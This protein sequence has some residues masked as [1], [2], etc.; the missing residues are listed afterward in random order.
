M[1]ILDEILASK[2]QE[3]ASLVAGTPPVRRTAPRSFMAHLRAHGPVALIAEIKR[4]S[5]SRPMIREAFE[6][7]AMARAYEAGGAA[8]LS[9]LTDAPYFGGSLSDMAAAREA[10]GLPVLRKD[11]LIDPR[12]VHEAYAAGADALLLI[13]AALTDDRLREMMA[14]CREVGLEFLLEVHTPDEMRR[15]LALEAPLVGINN[16]DLKTFTVDLAVTRELATLARTAE[17][18]PMLVSESGIASPEDRSL[19]EAWG[20]EAMLVGE[21]L[22]RQPD[23]TLAARE[24]LA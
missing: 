6:P 5:P 18:V 4:K 24:L 3:V 11:F 8:A 21:S 7:A 20:I 13:A 17:R 22:L 12:Q 19:L 1:T 9:V 2:A 15:A 14:V 10:V 23:L 16:R